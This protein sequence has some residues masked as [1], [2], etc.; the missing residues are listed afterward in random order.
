MKPTQRFSQAGSIDHRVCG[1]TKAEQVVC[2][3]GD[4][5]DLKPLPAPPKGELKK[6]VVGERHVCALDVDGKVH[7]WGGQIWNQLNCPRR[8]SAPAKSSRTRG[9]LPSQET[10]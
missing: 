5:G 7:C 1:I 8:A 9:S 4:E 3:D 10:L 6:V 2:V